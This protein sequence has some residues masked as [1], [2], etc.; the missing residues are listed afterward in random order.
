MIVLLLKCLKYFY[1]TEFPI[2][3]KKKICENL[4]KQLFPQQEV[5]ALEIPFRSRSTNEISLMMRNERT[6][7]EEKKCRYTVKIIVLG[8]DLWKRREEIYTLSKS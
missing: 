3:I 8:L 4:A 5:K 6:L 1:R 7:C 2:E